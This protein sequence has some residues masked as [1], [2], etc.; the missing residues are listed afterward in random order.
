M[1]STKEEV[2][3]VRI[4][5]LLLLFVFVKSQGKNS[6]VPK[7]YDNVFNADLGILVFRGYVLT[8][9]RCDRPTVTPSKAV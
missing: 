5:L 9:I 3:F 2:T 6:S 1:N 7:S 8:M 4:L